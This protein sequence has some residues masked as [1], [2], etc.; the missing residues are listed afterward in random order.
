MRKTRYPTVVESNTWTSYWRIRS[1]HDFEM[2]SP[3]G[4]RKMKF[5]PSTTGGTKGYNTR[6]ERKTERKDRNTWTGGVGA[7]GSQRGRRETDETSTGTTSPG[8]ARKRDEP[9]VHHVR[10]ARRRYGGRETCQRR[11]RACTC[12]CVCIIRVYDNGE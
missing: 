11:I 7:K 8:G 2:P 6:G 3:R 1:L 4:S 10:P 5:E 12:A 9:T